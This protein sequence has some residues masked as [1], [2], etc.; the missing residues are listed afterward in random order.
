MGFQFQQVTVDSTQNTRT[1]TLKT[2]SLSK[3]LLLIVSVLSI[4]IG[5]THST[6]GIAAAGL[7]VAL[8]I[9]M[10]FFGN[11]FTFD[12]ASKQV[13]VCSGIGVL[14][15]RSVIPFDSITMIAIGDGAG[16]GGKMSTGRDALANP[17][18]FRPTYS[19]SLEMRKHPTKHLLTGATPEVL[20]REAKELA[21]MSG[22]EV[23]VPSY[24]E[25]I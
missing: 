16:Y 12:A 10:A 7:V 5:P 18:P 13:V 15:G 21:A 19:L 6:T 24:L 23:F 3:T 4:G 22:K 20:V 8:S 14:R 9:L 1:L 17:R 25:A 11:T 2:T